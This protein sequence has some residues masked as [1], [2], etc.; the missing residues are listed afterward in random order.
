MIERFSSVV[1]T[2][3]VPEEGLVAGDSGTV[4]DIYDDGVAYEVEFF[5]LSG[6]TVAVVTIESGLIRP[7]TKAD[8]SH[9]RTL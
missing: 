9:A 8:V 5:A 6:D 2:E 3:G 1:L 7:A 4:I